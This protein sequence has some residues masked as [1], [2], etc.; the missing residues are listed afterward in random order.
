MRRSRRSRRLSGRCRS[1]GRARWIVSG[2]TPCG[3]HSHVTSTGSPAETASSVAMEPPASSGRLPVSSVSSQL[4][5]ERVDR[6][7][8]PLPG[9]DRATARRR[10]SNRSRRTLPPRRPPADEPGSTGVGVALPDERSQCRAGIAVEVGVRP[11]CRPA[12][13][14]RGSG[15]TRRTTARAPSGPSSPRATS[16]GAPRCDPHGCRCGRR[17]SIVGVGHTT[18]DVG[19]ANLPADRGGHGIGERTRQRSDAAAGL[20]Q[21]VQHAEF[22]EHVAVPVGRGA[23]EPCQPSDPVG[24]A[25]GLRIDEPGGE[26]VPRAVAGERRVGEPGAHPVVE[27]P[28]EFRQPGV[29]PLHPFVTASIPVRVGGIVRSRQ[30]VRH[31]VGGSPRRARCRVRACHVD[32]RRRCRFGV[33]RSGTGG[34]GH[35]ARRRVGEMTARPRR[36]AA[37]RCRRS[38]RSPTASAERGRVCTAGDGSGTCTRIRRRRDRPSCRTAR[39]RSP[40]THPRPPARRHRANPIGSATPA[41]EQQS[42]SP[43]SG[44]SPRPAPPTTG[45]RERDG[46]DRHRYR[47]GSRRIDCIG[48]R[49]GVIARPGERARLDVADAER[50]TELLPPFELGGLGVADDREMV[51]GRA[52][53]LADRHDVDAEVGEVGQAAR[54]SRRR[55]RRGRP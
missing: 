7:P 27:P 34:V 5:P 30:G 9:P 55:S 2:T 26:L 13:T 19:L 20:R 44:R 11:T 29:H 25:A 3:V 8:R 54:R 1:N 43:A 41:A 10:A 15:G 33:G 36:R 46:P 42:L 22:G 49:L 32:G 21:Q 18:E 48:G 16:G 24:E 38:G 37:R 51:R 52:Q 35:L 23:D 40:G 4:E 31:L 39:H 47:Y 14:C 6:R 12:A 53:V 50:L 17:R 45:S 28:V